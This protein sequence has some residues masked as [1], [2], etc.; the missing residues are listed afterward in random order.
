[1]VAADVLSIESKIALIARS[2]LSTEAL[3]L[4]LV[5]QSRLQLIPAFL[6]HRYFVIWN[7]GVSPVSDMIE[8]VLN[9]RK[10]LR[11]R[12]DVKPSVSDCFECDPRNFGST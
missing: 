7:I 8:T 9:D 6:K 12:I 1:M 10:K 4:D 3:T 11:T 5:R 2:R